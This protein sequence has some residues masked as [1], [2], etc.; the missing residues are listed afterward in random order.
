MSC[1]GLDQCLAIPL[2]TDPSITEIGNALDH[3]YASDG[4][5][6]FSSSKAGRMAGPAFRPLFNFFRIVGNSAE[7]RGLLRLLCLNVAFMWLELVVGQWTN[8]L[9]LITDAFHSLFACAAI[10]VALTAA[11]MAK[12]KPTR[13][14][15]YGCVPPRAPRLFTSRLSISLFQLL[16]LCCSLSCYICMPPWPLL[17]CCGRLCVGTLVFFWRAFSLIYY[18]FSRPHRMLTPFFQP[19]VGAGMVEQ[20][21]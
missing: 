2:V 9:A 8:S 18:F 6:M 10:T 7:T 4:L 19:L 21:C 17:C 13:T 11:V 16:L 20:R 14:Y 15:S 12:W 5:P 3:R 1:L